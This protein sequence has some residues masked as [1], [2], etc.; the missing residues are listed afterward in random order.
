[1]LSTIK[2][3][4]TTFPKNVSLNLIFFYTVQTSLY[5]FNGTGTYFLILFLMPRAMFGSVPF[6]TLSQDGIFIT[7]TSTLIDC[8]FCSLTWEL[9]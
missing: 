8:P 7:I 4:L 5:M 3:S 1:M 2:L 9:S 6:E